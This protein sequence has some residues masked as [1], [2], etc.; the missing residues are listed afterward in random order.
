[1]LK[2][3]GKYGNNMIIVN[4]DNQASTVMVDY[5]VII[6]WHNIWDNMLSMML[7]MIWGLTLGNI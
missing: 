6:R 1:M 4:H 5:I 2:N 3:M 7:D